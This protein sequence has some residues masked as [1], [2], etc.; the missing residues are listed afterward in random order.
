[1]DIL[2]SE[3][4]ALIHVIRD[5]VL[6]NAWVPPPKSPHLQSGTHIAIEFLWKAFGE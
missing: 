1:M 5:V 6:Y 3:Q 2:L 4:A